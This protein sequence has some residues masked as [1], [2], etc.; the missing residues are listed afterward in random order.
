LFR[1][2]PATGRDIQISFP[3]G[4][5]RTRG[6]GHGH[7]E[8]PAPAAL[9]EV[10]AKETS[11]Q[12]PPAVEE[13]IMDST[14][15][16]KAWIATVLSEMSSNGTASFR[17]TWFGGLGALSESQV[18]DRILMTMNFIERELID[19]VR[20]VYPANQAVNTSCGNMGT[21]AYVWKWFSNEEGYAET[22]GPLCTSTQDPFGNRC[23]IDE[24]GRY[25]VYLCELWFDGI[26]TNSRIS[27]LVHEASHHA[28]PGDV[29]YDRN[30]MKALSQP[31]QLNNAA[32]YQYFAQ[33]VAQTT[34]GCPDSPTV[35]GLPFTCT[36]SPCTCRAFQD[37]CDDQT[38]GPQ[39][40]QQCPA[41]CGLCRAPEG[42]MVTTTAA[43]STTTIATTTTAASSAT[44]IAS[45]TTAAPGEASTAKG[46][47][48]Q[49]DATVSITLGGGTYEGT[50]TAFAWADFCR[51][52]AVSA[53]CPV[54]C[55]TCVPSGCED[56]PSYSIMTSVGMLVCADWVQYECWDEVKAH[57]PSSCDV[58]ECGL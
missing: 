32:N 44:T 7:G 52:E 27:T 51:E 17:S 25:F 5:G 39:I 56:D 58:G 38:F 18:R 40:K 26:G 42:A 31:S 55:R 29:T 13:Q 34:W 46:E 54:S 1:F 45:T 19:G 10:S 30:Y 53:Q 22:V 6:H 47:C 50:C 3:R 57:C 20:Y 2:F 12:I 24:T 36:P 33:D 49:P 37:M 4:A 48:C 15:Q 8:G 21:I 28:G 43:A 16:A 11:E 14:A 41:T 23:G 35:T 9:G